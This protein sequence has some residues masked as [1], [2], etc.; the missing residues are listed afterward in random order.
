MP[1]ANSA[2]A[3][4]KLLDSTP[5]NRFYRFR[6]VTAGR[7]SCVVRAPFR[8]EFARPDGI[9]AGII[10]L[11]AADVAMWMAI[12]TR[13]GVHERAVTVEMKS[14]FLRSA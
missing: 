2:R 12:A 1:P 4:Q 14:N 6:V 7:G 5:F 8:P 9:T 13:I 10:F 3:L 11:A